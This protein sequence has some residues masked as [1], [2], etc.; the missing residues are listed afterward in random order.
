[1]TKSRSGSAA[2]LGESQPRQRDIRWTE[3]RREEARARAAA[4]WTPEARAQQ[5]EL[6]RRKM[7]APEV[8][9]RITA[10]TKIASERALQIEVLRM[11]WERAEKSVRVKFLAEIAGL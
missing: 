10:G 4:Q 2:K 8:R 1:M 5:S 3:A 9:E 7:N 11:A 6:T